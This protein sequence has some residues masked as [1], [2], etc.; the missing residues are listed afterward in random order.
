MNHTEWF[1]KSSEFS[2][3][4]VVDE[5][6]AETEVQEI[7]ISQQNYLELIR[8]ETPSPPIIEYQGRCGEVETNIY[9]EPVKEL[10]IESESKEST[11]EYQSVPVKDLIN[12]YEQGKSLQLFFWLPQ[13][14]WQFQRLT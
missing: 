7:Y 6:A 8:Q 3:E 9:D 10:I 12:N 4:S 13:L 5:E 14:F 11:P 2:S 1:L